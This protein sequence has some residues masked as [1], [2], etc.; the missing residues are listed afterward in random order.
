MQIDQLAFVLDFVDTS[1]HDTELLPAYTKLIAAVEQAKQAVDGS[2]EMVHRCREELLALHEQIHPHGWTPEQVAVLESYNAQ[3]LIGIPAI[4][5]IQDAFVTNFMSPKPLMAELQALH[6]ETLAL[7]ERVTLLLT[8]LDPVLTE[9]PE[10][11]V[12]SADGELIEGEVVDGELRP[13]SNQPSR[14]PLALIRN[15][16]PNRS[17]QSTAL[18]RADDVPLSTK[19]IAAAP[20]VLAAAGK[21]LEVYRTYSEAKNTLA[22]PEKPAAQPPA[23]P[24]QHTQPANSYVRYSYSRSVYITTRDERGSK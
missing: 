13:M 7:A 22:K 9:L 17:G 4:V 18:V 5:R 15:R 8:G 6:D 10:G 11:V 21:A 19:L 23:V 20:V 24:V 14:N 12:A 3:A 2:L 1:I 16:M